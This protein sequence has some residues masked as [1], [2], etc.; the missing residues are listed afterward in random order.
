VAT[1]AMN[2]RVKKETGF[3]EPATLFSH[4]HTLQGYKKQGRRKDVNRVPRNYL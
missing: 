4:L 1:P 2:I 3:Q